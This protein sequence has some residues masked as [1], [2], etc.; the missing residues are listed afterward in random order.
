MISTKSCWIDVNTASSWV[1]SSPKGWQVI[2]ECWGEGVEVDLQHRRKTRGDALDLYMKW[3]S[4]M[5]DKEGDGEGLD[6]V[7]RFM[8]LKWDLGKRR[9]GVG[10]S[11]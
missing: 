4:C 7:G 11:S 6:H 10:M 5:Q 2:R 9:G 8:G 1:I 3:S